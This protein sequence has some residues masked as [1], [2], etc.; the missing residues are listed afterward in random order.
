[1]RIQNN[2][3]AL[4]SVRNYTI[5]GRNI[6]SVMEKL[7]SG[8]RINRAGD[9]AAGL[10]I[11]EKMRAQ[12]RG[13]NRASMNCQDGISLVQSADGALTEVHAILH[14]M[15]ELSIQAANDINAQ[16]DRQAIQ[17]EIDQLVS[18]IDRI[19]MTTSFNNMTILDGSL[20]NGKYIA[21]VSGG[22][23]SGLH[24]L[25]AYD[26]GGNSL[27]IDGLSAIAVTGG[28]HFDMTFDF[29][30]PPSI[31]TP[32]DP[33][34]AT[35]GVLD[36][37]RAGPTVLD[38]TLGED[39][40]VAIGRAP[41]PA[42]FP[43][44]VVVNSGDTANIIAGNVRDM[45][46]TALGHDWV[47]TATG[48]RVNVTHRFV[49]DFGGDGDNSGIMIAANPETM[50]AAMDIWEEASAEWNL[51]SGNNVVGTAGRDVQ[52][53]ISGEAA[54]FEALN[55]H[56]WQAGNAENPEEGW[57]RGRDTI[58]NLAHGEMATDAADADHDTQFWFRIDDA[59][60]SSGAIISTR[61]G[62]ELTLQVGANAGYPQTLRVS[63]PQLSAMTLG[64]ADL[65]MFTHADSQLAITAIDGALQIV[66]D[67]RAELGAVQNRMEHTIANLETVAENLT[68]A[69]SR[70][71]DADIVREMM[72]FTKQNILLQSSQA[73]SAQA[74]SIPQ[75]V[76]RLLG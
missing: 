70:M 42:A 11:S 10:A 56:E 30:F 15:R 27:L 61:Q 4:N 54:N 40:L 24:L 18:E 26:D 38:I 31:G 45:L 53:R 66:T 57:L 41:D 67:V 34:L 59:S 16:D 17:N 44:S 50:G 63:I 21:S 37:D 35:G 69:E 65:R 8:F 23:I 39:I 46:R 43:L 74:N 19:S 75:G 62:S 20:Q 28:S 13:L 58:L 49:G 51:T 1:M 48:S 12:I 3:I 25:N 32:G 9:D 2:I 55:L 71:R 47:V 52:V 14:R 7:S 6:S 60:V 33:P 68:E 22:N 64:V 76:L 29:A 36:L 72:I 5:N 73:M